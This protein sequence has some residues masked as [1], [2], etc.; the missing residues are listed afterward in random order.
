[1]AT[2]RRRWGRA[3]LLL[4][5]AVVLVVGHLLFWYGPRLRPSRPNPRAMTAQLLASEAYDYALWV[6]YPHQSLGLLRGEGGDFLAAAA[7]L[8]GLELPV[9]PALGAAAL[10]PCT[11]LTLAVD[12]KGERFAAV[13][14][15]Y[16]LVAA[17]LRLAGF[18]ADNPLLGGGEVELGGRP[19]VVAWS[20]RVWSVTSPGGLA[21]APWEGE[22]PAP[23]LARLAVRRAASALPIGRYG[24][25]REAGGLVFATDTVV[26]AVLWQAAQGIRGQDLVLTAVEGGGGLKPPRAFAFFAAGGLELPRAASLYRPDGPRWPLPGEGLLTLAGRKLRRAEA[27]GWRIDAYSRSGLDTVVGLAPRLRDLANPGPSGRLQHGLWLDLP[28]A[29]LEVKRIADLLSAL[30][31]LPRREV[32]PWRDA[33]TVLRPLAARYSTLTAVAATGP[34]ALRLELA[35][36]AAPAAEN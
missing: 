31:L 4:T 29:H 27:A 9:V 21:L 30:P 16:P 36:A 34:G 24:L 19:A 26:P 25:R 10:P 3:I 1:M 13:V 35:A 7:R 14:R 20:G 23:S 15:V 8:V 28:G 2:P 32:R 22:R 18:L 5:L 17:F 33:V 12:E 6:P 11:D